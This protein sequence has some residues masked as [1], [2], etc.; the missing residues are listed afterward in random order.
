MV[1]ENYATEILNS[2]SRGNFSP[3]MTRDLDYVAGLEKNG[4]R[5]DNSWDGFNPL[6]VVTPTIGTLSRDD[7][8][9]IRVEMAGNVPKEVFES[10][11]YLRM[12]HNFSTE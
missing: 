2:N 12:Y 7:L 4:F 10:F 8:E 11:D 9:K 3:E 6:R 1:G 5:L